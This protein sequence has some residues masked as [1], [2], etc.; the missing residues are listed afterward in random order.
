M[1]SGYIGNN[2]SLPAGWTIGADG[3]EILEW[4]QT[5]LEPHIYNIYVYVYNIYNIYMCKYECMYLSH[6]GFIED[7]NIFLKINP[8]LF[9]FYIYFEK[10]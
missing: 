7:M 3:L 8:F 1:G 2:M 6:I 5:G 10:M 4:G 9:P